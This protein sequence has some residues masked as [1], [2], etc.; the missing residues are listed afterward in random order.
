MQTPQ[1]LIW[2]KTGIHTEKCQVYRNSSSSGTQPIN[3]GYSLFTKRGG[4]K[5]LI[6]LVYVDDFVSVEKERMLLMM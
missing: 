6:L 1:I 3:D 4:D 2:R 5:S